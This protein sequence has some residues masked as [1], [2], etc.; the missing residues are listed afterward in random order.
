MAAV[1]A[2]KME[3]SVTVLMCFAFL[4]QSCL[5]GAGLQ[6]PEECGENLLGTNRSSKFY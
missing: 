5:C 6:H 1:I 4:F 2:H 3:L